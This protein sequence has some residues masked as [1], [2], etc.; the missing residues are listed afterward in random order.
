MNESDI[1]NLKTLLDSLVFASTKA[2]A[3]PIYNKLNFKTSTL[4]GEIDQYSLDKLIEAISYA[5]SA[6]GQ[7]NDKSHW[8]SNM[9]RSWYVFEANVNREPQ[10]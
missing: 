7:V 3:K 6:S 9:E 4:S 5:Y 10:T 1:S 2:D 8:Q